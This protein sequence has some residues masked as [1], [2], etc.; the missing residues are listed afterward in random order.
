MYKLHCHRMS[1]GHTTH[2]EDAELN[3]SIL[4]ALDPCLI[5]ICYNKFAAIATHGIL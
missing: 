2:Y 4:L 5:Y 1:I 3:L